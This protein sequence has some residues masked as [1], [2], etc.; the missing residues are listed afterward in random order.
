MFQIALD[1]DLDEFVSSFVSVRIS[2]ISGLE[3][4]INF[5]QR[6]GTDPCESGKY[7][8]LSRSENTESLYL[9]FHFN[10]RKIKYL[11]YFLNSE[12]SS[13]VELFTS[14]YHA[15]DSRQPGDV[16]DKFPVHYSRK[17]LFCPISKSS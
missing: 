10:P 12:H 4:S 3:V 11:E 15:M 6:K 2:F 7:L 13:F 16:R 5:L 14:I 9:I 8:R 17:K 1:D